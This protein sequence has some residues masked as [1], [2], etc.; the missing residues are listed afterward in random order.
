MPVSQKVGELMDF[1]IANLHGWLPY[2][3]RRALRMPIAERAS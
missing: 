3:M 2:R 1:T